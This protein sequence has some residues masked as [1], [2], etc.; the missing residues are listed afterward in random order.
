MR[1]TT[2]LTAFIV[3]L[4]LPVCTGT[5]EQGENAE[6]TPEEPHG[7]VHQTQAEDISAHE[8]ATHRY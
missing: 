4:F 7:T 1:K 8:E 6:T 3:F 5:T 2:L